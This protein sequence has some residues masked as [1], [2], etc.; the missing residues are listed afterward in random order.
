MVRL[1]ASQSGWHLAPES[2]I[3][4]L[5]FGTRIRDRGVVGG[6]MHIEAS[7]GVG[8]QVPAHTLALTA[9]RG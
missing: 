8:S 9:A 5:A 1:E 7:P 4:T 6:I 3:K 2:G